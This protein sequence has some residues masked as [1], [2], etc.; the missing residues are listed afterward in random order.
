MPFSGFSEGTLRFLSEL[1]QNNERSWFERHGQEYE[2]A[3][4]E[5]AKAFV[6]ALGPALRLLD[7]QLRASPSVRGSIKPQERRQRFA[8]R[9]QPP[10]REHLDLWFW[11][12]SRRMWENSGF[13]VRLTPARLVLAVGMIHL[14]KATLSRYREQVLDEARGAALGAIVEELR[15]AGYIVGG[16]S[17]KKTPRGVPA[18]HPRASLLKHG[19]L[20]ASHDV[21]HPPELAR[22]AF[23]DFA[24]W[25]F[26]R[27]APLHAWLL[28]LGA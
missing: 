20:F 27:M 14:Q 6:E 1:S 26:T 19:A 15:A 9:E 22:P 11:S 12:G 13:F 5:P 4:L 17:Y 8:A 3:L 23:V 2:R 7:P 24:L 25:H 21:P 18:D 28:P 16:E 10:Y